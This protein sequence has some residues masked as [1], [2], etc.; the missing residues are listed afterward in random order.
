MKKLSIAASTTVK[1]LLFM[2]L[3]SVVVF[4]ALQGPVFAADGAAGESVVNSSNDCSGGVDSNKCGITKY[5]VIFTNALSA[6]VGVVIVFSIVV[7]GIQYMSAGSNP[8]AVSK[9]KSRIMNALLALVVYLFMFG[10]LQWL[11]PGGVL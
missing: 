5:I 9:A 4:G 10:L 11:V 6:L 7:G 8:Q 3:T 2:A 1:M